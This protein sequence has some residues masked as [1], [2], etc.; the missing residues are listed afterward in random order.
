MRLC[1]QKSKQKVTKVV[2][3][4][5]ITTKN[6]PLVLVSLKKIKFAYQLWSWNSPT[7]V[8][9][10]KFAVVPVMAEGRRFEVFGVWVGVRSYQT[11]NNRQQKEAGEKPIQHDGDHSLKNDFDKS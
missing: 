5:K 11:E 2:Y 3:P 4:C 1:V 8:G 7:S 10:H 6:L 9:W